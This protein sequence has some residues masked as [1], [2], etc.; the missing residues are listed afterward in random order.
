MLLFIR[1][2]LNTLISCYKAYCL[3]YITILSML[4]QKHHQGDKHAEIYIYI[5]IYIYM[6]IQIQSRALYVHLFV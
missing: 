4:Q 6:S 1:T 2:Q 5:Y 3:H